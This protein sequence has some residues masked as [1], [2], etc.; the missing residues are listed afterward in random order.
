MATNIN[1]GEH[2]ARYCGFQ[3]LVHEPALSVTP[4][5]FEL[6]H[7]VGETYLSVNHCEHHAGVRLGQLR[8][9]LND[10]DAKGFKVAKSGAL[11]VVDAKVIR[12]CGAVRSRDL[13]VRRRHHE[14][15]R[16]YAS[17]DGMPVDNSDKDLLDLLAAAANSEVHA[18][19]KI[20]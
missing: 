7:G 20:P 6:R 14:K 10:L 4:A 11:A 18:I 17:I 15:D 8:G 13:R 5:A 9:I 1:D 3:K 16:S 19:S 12:D 2:I